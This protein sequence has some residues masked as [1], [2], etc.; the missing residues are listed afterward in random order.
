[1]TTRRTKVLAIATAAL[2]AVSLPLAGLSAWVGVSTGRW[3][4]GVVR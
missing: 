2:L 4:R 3:L 1:M